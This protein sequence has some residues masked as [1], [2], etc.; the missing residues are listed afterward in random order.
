[1]V[2][3]LIISFFSIRSNAVSTRC[4]HR[5][6]VNVHAH[7]TSR[8]LSTDGDRRRCGSQYVKLDNSFTA[9]RSRDRKET[10]GVLS[11]KDTSPLALGMQSPVEGQLKSGPWYC[12]HWHCQS[13]IYYHNNI[14]TTITTWQQQQNIYY[15]IFL[16]LSTHCVVL[17]RKRYYI[18]GMVNRSFLKMAVLW[19]L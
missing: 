1:M 12:L 10:C 15:N 5:P 16:S 19:C 9:W 7:W 18:Q 8:M 14:T 4:C 2:S 3:E 17:R 6:V 13:V 11:A